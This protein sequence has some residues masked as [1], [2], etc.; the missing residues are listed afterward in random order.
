MLSRQRSETDER[1]SSRAGL[2]RDCGASRVARLLLQLFYDGAGDGRTDDCFDETDEPA[3]IW[4]YTT[5][6]MFFSSGSKS[7]QDTTRELNNS[8]VYLPTANE[9]SSYGIM[10][11]N[12]TFPRGGVFCGEISSI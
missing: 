9:S 4:G 7:S 8:F 3:I 2:L 5:F 11:F 10:F 6:C 1:S 12:L